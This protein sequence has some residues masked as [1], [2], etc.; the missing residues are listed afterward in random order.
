[1]IVIFGPDAEVKPIT[2]APY[3]RYTDDD[4][5]KTAR[6]SDSRRAPAVSHGR[7]RH[8]AANSSKI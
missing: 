2:E 4:L 7:I 6:I 1:M 8:A 5:A 3:K